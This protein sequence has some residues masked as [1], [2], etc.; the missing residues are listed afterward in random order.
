MHSSD[1]LLNKTQFEEIR[2]LEESLW[3]AESRFDKLLMDKVFAPDFFE[4]GRSGRT[5]S[6]TEM[7]FN[8]DEIQKIKATLPLPEFHARHLS[9]NVVQVTYISEVIYDGV[10]LRGIRS[11]IW[12][13]MEGRWRLRFHQGTPVEG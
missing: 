4:F 2:Q 3:R 10:V 6:R 13:L 7:L 12:S 11:S 5:Y 8:E 9:K 1:E